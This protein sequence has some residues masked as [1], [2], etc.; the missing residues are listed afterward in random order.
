MKQ[1]ISLKEFASEIR[2]IYNSDPAKAAL[3]IEEYAAQRL[4]GC[5][6]V[7]RTSVMEELSREFS[8]TPET[9][10]LHQ[11]AAE[12]EELTRLFSLLLGREISAPD[13]SSGEL[14]ER[15]S[16][17]FNTIFN[18]LN[19]IVKVINTTLLGR[20]EQFETI[21]KIIGSQLEHEGGSTS[22]QA[23]LDQIKSAFLVAHKSFKLAVETRLQEILAE[24]DPERI[25]SA[26]E[27]GLRFGPL[28]KAELYGIY[29]QR[30]ENV[31]RF[32]LSGQLTDEFVKEFE[33]NCEK[34]YRMQTGE[35]G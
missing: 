9:G 13:L 14:F 16:V 25:A 11:H 18:T 34:Q 23:Y 24:L 20:K 1:Q 3:L 30:Y 7:E 12:P 28:R 19:E 17:S 2:R 26:T 31:K 22:I 33:K 35:T 29:V 15:L 32:F 4:V 27:G 21:R 8:S 5:T 6:P 10:A